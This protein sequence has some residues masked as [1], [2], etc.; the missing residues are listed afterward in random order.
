MRFINISE[1]SLVVSGSAIPADE[2]PKLL[3]ITL[4]RGLA[5]DVHLAMAFNS[6]III[7]N[8]FFIV[9]FYINY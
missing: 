5:L 9:N 8:F 6:I 7:G 1:M 3:G 2:N 4:D